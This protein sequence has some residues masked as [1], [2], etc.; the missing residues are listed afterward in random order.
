MPWFD[1]LFALPTFGAQDPT[2]GGG[3]RYRDIRISN[4]QHPDRDTLVWPVENKA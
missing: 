2:D 4:H 3:A 1:D